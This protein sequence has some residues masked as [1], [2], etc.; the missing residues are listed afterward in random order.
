MNIK[1]FP[2]YD[3]DDHGDTMT[4]GFATTSASAATGALEVDLGSRP[5]GASYGTGTASVSIMEIGPPTTQ[6][7]LHVTARIDYTAVWGTWAS[8]W[9]AF[10]HGLG[11]LELAP[12]NGPQPPVIVEHAIFDDDSSLWGTGKLSKTDWF[13]MKAAVLMVPN[14]TYNATVSVECLIFA[15]G[16]SSKAIANIVATVPIISWF[17]I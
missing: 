6:K 5:I 10:T 14:Q 1:R 16:E 12:K 3:L 8:G 4:G 7:T 13:T 11:R 9:R 2:P 17:T 15:Q